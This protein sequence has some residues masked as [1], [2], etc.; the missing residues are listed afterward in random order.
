MISRKAIW[1]GLAVAVVLAGLLI[2]I[3]MVKKPTNT[4]E[5]TK[6]DSQTTQLTPQTLTEPLPNGVK[7]EMVR[8]PAGEFLMGSTDEEVQ[9]AY[10]DTKRYNS[11]RTLDSFGSEKPKHRV[12]IDYDFYLSQFEVTQTQWRAVMGKNPSYFQD[13]GDCPVDQ[14]SWNDAREFCQKLSQLIGREYRLPSEAEWE[15]ACR[16]G[17]TTVFAFGDSIS[18]LQANF[19]G[20]SP[21]GNAPKG[22]YLQ[23]TVKVGSYQPNAFGLYDM[24][25][26]VWEW[27]EDLLSDSYEGLP[28]DGSP[29]LS[30][31]LNKG[32]PGLRVLRGGSWYFYGLYLRSADRSAGS[33]DNRSLL[34][35]FRVCTSAAKS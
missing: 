15:Y 12:T 16:A 6:A 14:V 3:L 19:A 10:E 17:T 20:T 7:L 5:G 13:C 24:H 25:G 9:A 11:R 23:K 30:K 21:F 31:G 32:T 2:A 8:I 27:C 35:G 26:N 4:H 1:F 33:P 29:N 18:S 34:N 22:P 28:T